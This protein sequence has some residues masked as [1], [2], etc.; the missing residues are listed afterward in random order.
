MVH[1][2][3]KDVRGNN[4]TRRPAEPERNLFGVIKEIPWS[5]NHRKKCMPATTPTNVGIK[6]VRIS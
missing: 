4:S 2:G 3:K 1:A 6:I 5:I